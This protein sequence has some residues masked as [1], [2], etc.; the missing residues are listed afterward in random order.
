MRRR[1]KNSGSAGRHK[2]ATENNGSGFQR[3]DHFTSGVAKNWAKENNGTGFH[4]KRHLTSGVVKFRRQRNAR[5][6]NATSAGSTKKHFTSGP[7]H[8][9]NDARVVSNEAPLYKWQRHI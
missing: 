5:E 2:G 8:K 4:R 3:I 6:Q 1:V 7:P 9:A